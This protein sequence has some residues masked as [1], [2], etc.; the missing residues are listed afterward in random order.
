MKVLSIQTG[1]NATIALSY[2]GEIV[3][4]LGQEKCDNIK[5][6]SAFPMQAIE[7]L[8]K[9]INWH[10]QDI[11][12]V[13][14]CSE[15]IYPDNAFNYFYDKKGRIKDTS[16]LIAIAKSLRNSILGRFFP[17]IFQM[18]RKKRLEN[19]IIKGRKELHNKLKKIGFNNIPF[20][21]V[22]H[23]LCHAR[24]VY[25]SFANDKISGD[26]IIFTLD[27][28]GDNTC[29]SVT[30]VNKKGVWNK[31]AETPLESSLGNIYSF[32]TKFLGMKPLE[33]EY[34]VMGLAAYSKQNYVN[35]LYEKIFKPVIWLDEKNNLVL[36]PN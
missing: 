36:N 23:H 8:L 28:A 12:K 9:E 16:T 20:E 30:Y 21:H 25:H 3:G 34:K 10:K 27:G 26:S 32:T 17:S 13:L 11:E 14:I 35:S 5:N 7:S 24:A 1:H 18:L 31:I 4:V 6:S 15:N 19:L 33:H 22:E 2:K 29:S